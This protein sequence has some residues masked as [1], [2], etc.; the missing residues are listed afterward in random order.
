MADN[1]LDKSE[2]AALDK[3]LRVL[4]CMSRNRE[5]ISLGSLAEQVDLPKPTLVRL[6]TTFKNHSIVWQDVRTR[7]YKLG[8]G[9]IYLGQAAS[10]SFSLVEV[11]RPYL[12]QLSSET[13]ET[14]SLVMRRNNRAVYVDQVSSN[15]MIRGVPHIG[16]ELTFYASGSGKIL[17]SALSER[18]LDGIV[19]SLDFVRLTDKTITDKKVFR[20]EL[21]QVRKRGWALD[22]EEGERGC[23]C[24]AAPLCDWNEQIIASISITGPTMRIE[25]AQIPILAEKVCSIAAAAS[26]ELRVG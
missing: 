2:V 19:D 13:G 21:A 17:L 15:N 11:I 7:H 3:A 8:W 23:R 4:E 10:A 16:E 14:A 24:I 20:D 9:L 6:L 26:K 12:A 1:N 5:D 25:E 18:E 22:D